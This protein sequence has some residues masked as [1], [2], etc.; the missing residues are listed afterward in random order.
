MQSAV[1]SAV[2]GSTTQ[3]K[4]L[5]V[6]ANNLA[7]VN[8]TGYKRVAMSFCN[9]F[10]NRPGTDPSITQ[11]RLNIIHSDLSQGGMVTTGNPLDIA[12]QGKG[13]FKLE[14][15]AGMR[16]SRAGNFR[17]DAQ[18][19]VIDA[20]GN[21]LQG[22]RGPLVVPHGT[23]IAI[24]LA[25]EIMADDTKIGK[26]AVVNFDAAERLESEGAH[27]FRLPRKS[28]AKEQP[29]KDALVHQGFLENSNVEV[30]REM[31]RMIEVARNVE[32][33]QKIMTTSASM[34]EKVINNVGKV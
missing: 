20:H 11:T 28:T 19:T 24:N 4:R 29:A 14:T 31:V 6:I 17:L 30:V 18:G 7:N 1:Y 9:S 26:I 3:G 34:D 10:T 12:I 25:G 32:A 13:F 2:F 16:Y 15:P 21:P 22:E 8:T 33:E 5:D 23:K 27:F